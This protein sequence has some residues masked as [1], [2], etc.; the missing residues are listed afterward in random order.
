MIVY[1]LGLGAEHFYPSNLKFPIPTL[2]N[3]SSN[4][5]HTISPT[6]SFEE[7]WNKIIQQIEAEAGG[8]TA[9]KET[10]MNIGQK[11][12]GCNDLF[13]NNSSGL[14]S[15]PHSAFTIC[16]FFVGMLWERFQALLSRTEKVE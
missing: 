6:E 12:W 5:I 16:I 2:K 7:L 15:N 4:L 1:G 8:T 11:M 3:K 9:E 13:W 14:R 10:K